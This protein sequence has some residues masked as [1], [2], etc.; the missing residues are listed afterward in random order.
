MRTKAQLEGRSSELD[1]LNERARSRR[2]ELIV[3]Y[4]GRRIG[5]FI[6]EQIEQSLS[7]CEMKFKEGLIL[8]ETI[9]E[10]EAKIKKLPIIKTQSI[11]RIL[12]APMILG[13]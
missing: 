9:P 2:A 1:L 11:H 7:I 5:Q 6:T 13:N 12:I 8:T 4:G 3:I 10:I